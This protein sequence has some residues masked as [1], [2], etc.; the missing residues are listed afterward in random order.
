MDTQVQPK[1]KVLLVGDSCIDEYYHGACNRVSPEAPVPILTLTKKETRPGMAANV[2]ENLINLGCSVHFVTNEEIITKS[3]Y[4]DSR[5]HQ[6]LRVDA[7]KNCKPC[8][9]V[10]PFGYDAVVISDYD[11]G[12]IT[13]E[14][15]QHL[16]K[17]YKGLIF[18][19][20]KKRDLAKF[21]GCIVKVNSLEFSKATSVC[22]NLI[23]TL[24]KD[25]AQ[26]DNV[27]Y[28]TEEISVLDI[29]GAGDTFLAALVY[30]YLEVQ[31]ITESIAFA[32]RASL[33]TVQHSG[34]YA[35]TLK[36][37]K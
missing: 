9:G 20:T 23:V 37:I 24:G 8:L 27:K 7:D 19:D 15:V 1:F 13:Y 28:P 34:V 29:T 4:L 18:V 11:K 16:R 31:D 36:E 5:G 12:F 33:V 2:R 10:Y 17:Q 3:R 22:S 6:L 35:P 30:K 32:N 26:L 25:G 14:F 21:E